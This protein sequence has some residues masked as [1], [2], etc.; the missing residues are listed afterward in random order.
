LLLHQR[1]RFN[2]VVTLDE[3]GRVIGFLE[4]PTEDAWRG[5]DS[6]WVNSGICI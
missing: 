4:R 2:S 5:D 1:V 6:I 3:A